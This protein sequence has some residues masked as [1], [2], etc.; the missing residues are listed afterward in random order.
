MQDKICL[1][2]GASAGIGQASAQALAQSGATVV[3]LCRN[4][5]KADATIKA[6]RTQVP[7]A[8]VDLLLADLAEMAQ[9]RAAAQVF[10][11][12]YPK[13]DILIHNAGLINWQRQVTVDGYE[14]C[15]AVNHLAVHLL[16]H[17]LMPK[18]IASKQ[19]R[20]ITVSS[21]LHH[22]GK[23]DFEDLMLTKNYSGIQA[24]SRSK[25]AN[26]YFTY[27]L[28]D[29]MRSTPMSINAMAPGMVAT[30]ISRDIPLVYRLAFKW[31]GKSPQKGAKTIL[32]LASDPKVQTIS[33]KF[34]QNEKVKAT[35]NISLDIQ[36]A[37]DLKTVSDLLTGIS[38]F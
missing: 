18:L 5:Q 8:K 19:A 15:F 21:G 1:V 20:V 37:R 9:V 3:L 11:D 12:K 14:M 22:L 6:I 25:L 28:A 32:Y 38:M 16:T 24:Y 31:F 33:G 29:R 35:S 23:L 10:I 34:F 26:L 7:N 4:P 27:E 17:L 36:I 2:T 13:L 30:E